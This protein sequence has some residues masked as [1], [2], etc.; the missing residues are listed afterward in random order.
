MALSDGAKTQDKSTAVLWRAGLVG[1]PDNAGIEQC[2]RLKRIFIEKIRADQ[3]ALHLAQFGMRCERVLHFGGARFENIE[4]IPMATFEVFEH[5]AQL[6]RCGIGI[7]PEYPAYDMIGSNLIG[8]IEV[9]GF[10]CR[11]ER[12]DDDPGRVRAQIQYLAID[13]QGLRQEGSLAPCEIGPRDLRRR[14]RG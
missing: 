1:V 8:W 13:E 11:F 5:V 12:S 10:R 6:L 14:L 4:Q 9:S 3:T 7:E 2:R